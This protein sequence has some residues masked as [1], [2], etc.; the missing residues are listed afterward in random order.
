[1]GFLP[2]V[3]HVRNPTQDEHEVNRS[4]TH[5]LVG[6]VNATTHGVARL[7]HLRWL[8]RRANYANQ[9]AIVG[10]RAHAD[11]AITGLCAGVD[12]EN[13]WRAPLRRAVLGWLLTSYGRTSYRKNVVRVSSWD[14]SSATGGGG[15]FP[16]SVTHVESRGEHGREVFHC[17]FWKGARPEDG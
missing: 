12:A 10:K 4:V 8:H 17:R 13:E 1:V 14:R 6:N 16:R 15:D 9:P 5:S 3:V 11:T 2:E 7:G